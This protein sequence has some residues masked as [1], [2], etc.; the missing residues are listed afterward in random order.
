M[1]AFPMQDMWLLLLLA[2]VAAQ[3]EFPTSRC[4]SLSAGIATPGKA[5]EDGCK[6]D[7]G[8]S[9]G[10]CEFFSEAWGLAITHAGFSAT[11][12]CRNVGKA[13]RCSHTMDVVLT[14]GAVKDLAFAECVREQG[15]SAVDYCMQFQTAIG[16]AD[17]STDLDSLRACY[18]LEEE[19]KTSAA[20]I[21]GNATG[22]AAGGR[23]AASPPQPVQTN[24]TAARPFGVRVSEGTVPAEP[25]RV[26]VEPMHGVRQNGSA[27]EDHHILQGDGPLSSAGTGSPA[28]EDLPAV[29]PKT[30]E[31]LAVG[32]ATEAGA[33]AGA[34]AGAA[35]GETAGEEAGHAAG[36]E[37]GLDV[38][39]NTNITRKAV[40]A[41]AYKAGFDAGKD[42]GAAVVKQEALVKISAIMSKPASKVVEAI[43]EAAA[44]KLASKP[45]LAKVVTQAPKKA[46]AAVEVAPKAESAAEVVPKAEK[47]AVSQKVKET[48]QTKQSGKAEKKS[49]K[50]EKKNGKGEKTE[51]KEAIRSLPMAG[52]LTKLVNG[53]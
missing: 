43:H 31:Q 41:A 42:A 29:P 14:S 40:E 25:P 15:A 45:M 35:A 30:R 8:L 47:V 5:I 46:K 21:I 36:K 27:Y 20:P 1:C 50:S 38:A 10:Q 22:I 19:V 2:V 12:F 34:S 23:G 44:Q 18:L 17:H 48:V 32:A 49:E 24:S 33:A 16:E 13:L 51:D 39:A 53:D 37:V 3:R 6:S 26:T 7:L 9:S 11:D 4:E 28:S 52:F